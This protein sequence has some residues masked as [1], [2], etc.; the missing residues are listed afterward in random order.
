[1][2]HGSRQEK[3]HHNK[4][5]THLAGLNS[6]WKKG[7]DPLAGSR[8][9]RKTRPA[10]GSD[11][12]FHGLLID[13]GHRLVQEKNILVGQLLNVFIDTRPHGFSRL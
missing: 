3:R 4:K 8:L 13:P 12:F 10:Q 7:S 1:M 2:K 9:P 6:P 5:G 11:P